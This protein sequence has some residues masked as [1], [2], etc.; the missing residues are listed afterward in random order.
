[1]KISDVYNPAAAANSPIAPPM[2]AV[3]IDG[4]LA[5]VIDMLNTNMTGTETVPA[6][7]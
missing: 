6:N 1:M 4:V 5:G 7:V 2:F 3:V